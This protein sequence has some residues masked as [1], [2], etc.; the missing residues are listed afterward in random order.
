MELTARELLLSLYQHALDAVEG[1]YRVLQWFATQPSQAGRRFT[2]AVAIGKAAPSMLQGALDACA[3]ID[4]ALLIAPANAVPRALRRNKKVSCL[5]GPHPLPDAQSLAAGEALLQFV[6]RLPADARPL[7]LLSGGA[8]AMVEVLRA[9]VS[10]EQCVAANRYLLASGK[11]IE[12]M[13]AWRQRYSAIKAGGLLHHLPVKRVCQLLIS[14]V[15]D[16]NPAIIGSGLLTPSSPQTDDDAFLQTLLTAQGWPEHS[17][18][19]GKVEVETHV[20]AT[21]DDAMQ[22]C[23][24]AAE[25]EG[26]RAHIQPSRLQGDFLAGAERIAG[27]LRQAEPG[28]YIWGGELTVELPENPGIGGRCQ[29]LALRLA[30]LLEGTAVHVLAAG[31]DGIDGNAHC[32]GAAV[33]ADTLRRARAMGMDVEA[34]LARANA[35]T[36]LMA[37][38]DLVAPGPTGTNVTD[39]VIGWVPEG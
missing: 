36:V 14:D 25:A 10:L 15:P 38:D 35:G 39:I 5:P 2:H 18:E 16:D 21:L 7:F 29:S 22:A 34:E 11:P 3:A 27:V 1:R 33:S 32:A 31:T 12:R 19:Q 30:G 4:S 28:V 13:N 37:T 26:L 23:A 9:G 8:S 17:A 6:R 24:R 20:I